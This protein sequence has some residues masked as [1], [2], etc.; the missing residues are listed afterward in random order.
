LARKPHPLDLNPDVYWRNDY[1][2]LDFETTNLDHGR[3][4]NPGNNVVLAA[5]SIGNEHPLHTGYSSS[6][7]HKF[8][9]EYEQN[10]LYEAIARSSF[11]VAYN[12]KFELGWLLRAGVDLRKLIVYDPMIGEFVLAGNRKFDGGLSL[13]A[14]LQRY[15]IPGKLRYVSA[16]IDNGVCP[17]SIPQRELREYCIC[18]VRRTESLFL[19]QRGEIFRSGLQRVF[20]GRCL[21]SPMLADIEARGMQLDEE[22]IYSRYK[23]TNTEYDRLEGELGEAFGGINFRSSKQVRELVYEKLGFF[24]VR[25]YRGQPERTATGKPST[26]DEVLGKLVA[27]TEAQAK[28]KKLYGQLSPLKK[29]VS[30]LKN[31]V[32][33][34]EEDGGHVF[35]QFNQCVA[36]NHRLSSTGLKWGFNFQNFPRDFKTLFRASN[37][38]WVV[39]EGDCPQLEFRT[40]ID[41]S[42]DMVGLADILARADVHSLTSHVTGFSR[43]DSK[44]HTFKPMY[45]GRS[46]PKKLRDYYEAFRNRYRVMYD[47]QM[48]WVY[49]VLETKSLKISSGLVFYWPDTEITSSGYITNTPAIF[50]YPISSFATADISQLSLLLLWHHMGS[51]DSFIC[52]TIHD[53]GVLEACREELDKI[54]E[55]MVYCYTEEIYDC[56]DRLYGYNAVT[57][58]GLGFKSG[59]SF[60]GEGSE[61]KY[62]NDKR[63]K[64]TSDTATSIRL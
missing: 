38:T 17:S 59:S 14:T 40:G 63:F 48:G 53:S 64:F 60:W 47:M 12:A 46:G 32:G 34:C 39:A 18:D 8:G 49:R 33:A 58:F 55:L 20:Y 9:N 57:P 51:M 26:A 42:R 44:P 31:L 30:I 54:E 52:N 22:R 10:E 2:V 41:L 61:K 28:F 25:D 23:S 62:E 29:R 4:L 50:N 5:W 16:L 45:G 36:G 37:G 3:P 27:T 56:L 15:K 6:I 7:L 21:Q 19:Q 13:D 43:T 1:V 24:E 35:A 11:L